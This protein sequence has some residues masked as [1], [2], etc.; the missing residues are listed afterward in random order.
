M[1]IVLTF[2]GWWNMSNE[3]RWLH[4]C[5]AIVD[6]MVGGPEKYGYEDELE[7]LESTVKHHGWSDQEINDVKILRQSLEEE[8]C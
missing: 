2:K 6:N 4:E 5:R 8:K 3:D 1:A 7:I